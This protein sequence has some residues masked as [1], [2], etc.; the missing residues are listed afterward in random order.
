MIMEITPSALKKVDMLT[1]GKSAFRIRVVGSN[2]VGFH[3]AFSLDNSPK[4]DESPTI[5]WIQNHPKI[6]TD[7]ESFVYLHD[8]Q[9]D[10]NHDTDEFIITDSS[11]E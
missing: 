5:V 3:I 10:Y 7:Y 8:K 6:I 9:L 1:T 2:P 4:Y 11:K